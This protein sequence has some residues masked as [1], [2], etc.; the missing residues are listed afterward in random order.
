MRKKAISDQQLA[1]S[2]FAN[3]INIDVPIVLGI[4]ASKS[5]NALPLNS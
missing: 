3:I 4:I 5:A 2:K 1:I